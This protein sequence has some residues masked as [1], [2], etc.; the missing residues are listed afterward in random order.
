MAGSRIHL[1]L[2]SF[3]GCFSGK[4]IELLGHLIGMEIL[5]ISQ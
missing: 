4:C 1:V 5:Y 2:V 3:L